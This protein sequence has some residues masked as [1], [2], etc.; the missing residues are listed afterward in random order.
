MNAAWDLEMPSGM[1]FVLMSLCD[2]A[3]DAG[4]C[5]PS[6]ATIAKR[7]SMSERAVQGHIKTLEEMG[8]LV[9]KER[10]GHS[11]LYCLDPRR[12]C[13]PAESAPPQ[14][15]RHTPAKSAPPPPQNLHP[16]PAESAGDPRRICT[17]NHH[18]TTIEPPVEPKENQKRASVLRPDGVPEQVWSDFLKTRKGQKALLTETALRGIEREAEKAG[19]T[20]TAA[21]ETCCERGW[22]SFKADWQTASSFGR[23]PTKAIEEIRHEQHQT[24]EPA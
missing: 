19:I 18:L 21:L 14:K 12:F 20:L 15:L 4:Q 8:Y 3:N 1:K 7:C 23:R 2:Q 11:T 13:T 9:R 22:R 6:V 16:T 10:V 17:H 24:E 5:F